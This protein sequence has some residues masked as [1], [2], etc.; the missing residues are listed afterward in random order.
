MASLNS[1]EVCM[2]VGVVISDFVMAKRK[3]IVCVISMK[4][5]SDISGGTPEHTLPHSRAFTL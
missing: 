5:V 2:S 3:T 1:N 4:N